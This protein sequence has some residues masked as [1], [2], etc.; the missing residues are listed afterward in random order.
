MSDTSAEA[1]ERLIIEANGIPVFAA[2]NATLRALLTERDRLREEVAAQVEAAR[3]EEREAC[4][5]LLD[6]AAA[7]KER[8]GWSGMVSAAAR[9]YAAAIRARG[10]A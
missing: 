5:A 1:V 4:A 3:R 10:D 9:E 7:R 8:A 6:G 2:H